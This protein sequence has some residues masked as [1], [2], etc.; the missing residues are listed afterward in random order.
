[1]SG[2]SSPGGDREANR[3]KNAELRPMSTY[4]GYLLKLKRDQAS[5]ALFGRW[6]KRWFNI[7][8]YYLRWYKTVNLMQ[9]SGSIDLR[10]IRALAETRHARLGGTGDLPV[11]EEAVA[12]S[13]YCFSVDTSERLLILKAGS[14]NEMGQWMQQL[15]ML[16]DR[17]RGGDGSNMV[18]WQFNRMQIQNTGGGGAIIPASPRIT[19]TTSTGE[20]PANNSTQSDG[21]AH[22]D[23]LLESSYDGLSS[24]FGGSR[25]VSSSSSSRP[26]SRGQVTDVSVPGLSMKE[27]QQRKRDRKH[28]HAEQAKEGK[29][30]AEL[31]VRNLSDLEK[32]SKAERAKNM[33]LGLGLGNTDPDA[34]PTEWNT[35][36]EMDGRREDYGE[37]DYLGDDVIVLNPSPPSS[38]TAV[39]A[40]GGDGGGSGEGMAK[41][42]LL[43]NQVDVSGR[44]DSF[45]RSSSIAGRLERPSSGGGSM[46]MTDSSGNDNVEAALT[47]SSSSAAST[48]SGGAGSSGTSR[49]GPNTTIG[50][51]LGYSIVHNPN[52][53]QEVSPRPATSGMDVSNNID[54]EPTPAAT[55]A[56]LGRGLQRAAAAAVAGRAYAGVGR[57]TGD[58]GSNGVVGGSAVPPPRAGTSTAPPSSYLEGLRA[59]QSKQRKQPKPQTQAQRQAQ[60]QWAQARR[61]PAMVGQ[62]LVD[63]NADNSSFAPTEEGDAVSALTNTVTG[64]STG[65]VRTFSSLG[66]EGI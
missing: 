60:G 24:N 4:G 9:Y 10:Q 21:D 41:G 37:G 13:E 55:V 31:L 18:G 46:M 3:L 22:S 30:R 59:V 42:R 62:G 25:P 39:N 52:P 64:T 11:V 43:R 35:A 32:R 33:K 63:A 66:D 23:Y 45:S 14:R 49:G 20:S 8:G 38:P 47:T 26:G 28:A 6:N 48:S 36:S 61:Q 1:M 16:A 44:L 29:S 12:E 53:S 40:L 2:D 5:S 65:A 27:L 57:G 50:A 19:T 17:A 34:P 51:R 15:Q 56:A 54:T 58:T 7:E